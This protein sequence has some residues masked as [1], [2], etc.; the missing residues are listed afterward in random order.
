MRKPDVASWLAVQRRRQSRPAEENESSRTVEAIVAAM[1]P[2]QRRLWDSVSK[3]DAVCTA[4]QQGKSWAVLLVVFASCVQK[5][6]SQWAIVG[7]TKGALKRIYL[8]A[9]RQ[10]NDKF[11]IG[12]SHNKTDFTISL[13][14]GS[15]IYFLGADKAEEAEKLRGSTLEGIVVDEAQMYPLAELEYLIQDVADRALAV[16]KGRLILT[17]T[18]GDILQG[19]F[20]LATCT[21]AVR[22]GTNGSL[23]NYEYGSP[24]DGLWCKHIWSAQ[25]NISQ[26][27]IW[28]DA[29]RLKKQRGWADDHPKWMREYLGL[30]VAVNNILV[31]ADFLPAR[32]CREGDE[33]PRLP[34]GYTWYYTLGVD[35][36]QKDGTAMVVW[37]WSPASPNLYEVYSE[38]ITSDQL[39]TRIGARYL[40]SWYNRLLDRFGRF[41]AEVCDPGGLADF[42]LE[43]LA[44]DHNVFWEKAQV[45]DKEDAIEMFNDDCEAGRVQCI[46]NSPL[47]LELVNNRWLKNKDGY[48]P[49]R[50]KRTEDPAV[51]ND[52]CDAGL[53]GYRWC[54]HRVYREASA[55]AQYDYA[56][57]LYEAERERIRLLQEGNLHRED[58]PCLHLN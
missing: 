28:E 37:A 9:I 8:P 18:P 10:V 2:H 40:A 56:K 53:Y 58:D 33:L 36:G 14:N 50:G 48:V 49:P 41:A 6:R 19:E 42:V 21:P 55:Q 35:L 29:L 12:V 30:W 47:S 54:Y 16:K 24:P 44:D 15:I 13:P 22:L 52:L 38:K 31:Y 7:P 34:D 1:M 11:T 20:Y 5:P 43:S 4:R 32:N 23:S 45:R 25:A 17:G 51:P 46:R 3:R 39:G 26:P 57:A 27:H